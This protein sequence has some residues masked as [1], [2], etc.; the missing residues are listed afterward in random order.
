MV[1]GSVIV[2]INLMIIGWTREL[3]ALFFD[4]DTDEY[5]RFIVW[6]A[7]ISVYLLDFAINAGPY[8]PYCA[9]DSTSSLQSNYSRHTP[10]K[11]ARDRKCMGRQNGRR[12][13]FNRLYNVSPSIRRLTCIGAS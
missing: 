4:P 8:Y 11:Q 2:G 3:G 5:G 10:R 7:V 6:I 12:R 13:S 1:A 9:K